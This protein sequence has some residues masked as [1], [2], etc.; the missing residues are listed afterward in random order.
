MG[1]GYHTIHHTTYKHNYGHYF[2]FIDQ[3]YNTCIDPEEYDQETM[4]AENSDN[5]EPEQEQQEETTSKGQ[6]QVLQQRQGS[7]GDIRQHAA[8]A[9]AA[10]EAAMVRALSEPTATAMITAVRP[11]TGVTTRSRAKAL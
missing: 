3:M 4:E 2:T 10:T 7:A 1:A 9:A 6:Q 8:V 5:D 11:S